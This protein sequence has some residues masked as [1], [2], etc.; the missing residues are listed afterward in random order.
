[1]LEAVGLAKRYGGVR[2]VDAVSFEL[3]A[4][5]VLGLIGPNGAGKTTVF[6]LVSGFI[7]LDEGRVVLGGEDVDATGRRT[8]GR[9]RA[10]GA[11]SRTRACGRR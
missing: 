6:D 8:P 10:S 2:A 7:P 3:R 9:G 5:E 1:M 11:R 4:G